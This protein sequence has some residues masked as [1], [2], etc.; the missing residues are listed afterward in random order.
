[1]KLQ[2]QPKHQA[3]DLASIRRT[4]PTVIR[5]SARPIASPGGA[6][7]ARRLAPDVPHLYFVSRND[8]CT[9]SATT[10]EEPTR[11]LQFQ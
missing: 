6:S 5:A 7:I 8:C 9:F 1:M 4:P 2:V 3:D 11:T 10:L